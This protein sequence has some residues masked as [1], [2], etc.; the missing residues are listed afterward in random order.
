[1]TMP[2]EN[3]IPVK[4]LL[5][6]QSRPTMPTIPRVPRLFWICTSSVFSSPPSL[7]KNPT[8]AASRALRRAWGPDGVSEDRQQSEDQR[9]HADKRR[10]RHAGRVIPGVARAEGGYQPCRDTCVQPRWQPPRCAAS[11]HQRDIAFPLTAMHRRLPGGS[12]LLQSPCLPLRRRIAGDARRPS[13]R[14]ASHRRRGDDPQ[15]RR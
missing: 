4:R 2:S 10:E 14:S 11:Y 9:E 5:P 1:M 12:R 6:L 7:G 15:P 8:I 3:S 13:R